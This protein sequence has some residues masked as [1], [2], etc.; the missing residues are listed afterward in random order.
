M[1]HK[2]TLHSLFKNSSKIFL[3]KNIHI[4]VHV[5]TTIISATNEK[6]TNR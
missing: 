6:T 2:I 1:I 4:C 5:Y 3:T